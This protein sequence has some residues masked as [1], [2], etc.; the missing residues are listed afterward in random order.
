[1]IV[2]GLSMAVLLAYGAYRVVRSMKGRVATKEAAAREAKE[3]TEVEKAVIVPLLPLSSNLLRIVNTTGADW[4]SGSVYVNKEYS[5]NFPPLP[6]QGRAVL[7]LK[8]FRKGRT[9]FTEGFSN[10]TEITVAPPGFQ[11][12]TRL[13]TNASVVY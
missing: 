10:I 11:P 6:S 2:I 13:F 1:M 12:V 5:N 3:R 9:M 4:P 8:T 7:A